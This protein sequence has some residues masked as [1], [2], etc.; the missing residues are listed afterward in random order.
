MPI[1]KSRILIQLLC[2][3]TA[4]ILTGCTKTLP[5]PFRLTN[6]SWLQPRESLAGATLSLPGEGF[7]ALQRPTSLTLHDN[8]IY[9]VDA[10]LHRIFRYDRA[11]QTLSAFATDTPVDSN[12]S[13]YAAPD[14]SVY[15]TN[16]NHNEVLHFRRDGAS[17]PSLVSPGNLVRPVCVTVDESSGLVLVAD[18]QLNQVVVFD[19]WGMVLSIIN[20]QQVRSIDA[21]SIGPD[22]IY[23]LDRLAKRVVVLRKNGSF[24]YALNTGTASA[25]AVSHDNLV[26]VGDN[27]RHS[28]QVYRKRKVAAI[29]VANDIG[30]DGFNSIDALATDKNWLYIAD[31]LSS[32]VQIMQINPRE[33]NMDNSVQGKF[34]IIGPNGNFR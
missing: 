16:P 15:I 28:I 31:S 11:Q 1:S 20:L 14:A 5:F 2:I 18:G 13:L 26:F 29:I 32:R 7:V 21:M 30:P 8:D 12:T 23:I 22:G 3:F 25:M 19:H 34:L 24:R 10:G 33:M 27:F 9:L 17:L 4:G 6:T